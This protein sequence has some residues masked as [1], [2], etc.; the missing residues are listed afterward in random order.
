MEFRRLLIRP[1][2]LPPAALAGVALLAFS[3]A[4]LGSAV[5]PARQKLAQL[6]EE[7]AQ[8]TEQRRQRPQAV[9]RQEAD[10]PEVAALLPRPEQVVAQVMAVAQ[11]AERN[12]LAL[13]SGDYKLSRDR[14]AGVTAYQMDLPL[15]GTYPRLRRFLAEAVA[16][17]PGLALE[18]LSFKREQI[19]QG[20]VVGRARFTLY[21]GE[22]AG[23]PPAPGAR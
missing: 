23:A 12:Q 6:R 1:Q 2:G 18:E 10:L 4:F 13:D 3:L 7:L 17:V 15:H 19:G 21:V 20:D 22:A 16:Q 14:D 8:A 9:Q 5:L 11:A